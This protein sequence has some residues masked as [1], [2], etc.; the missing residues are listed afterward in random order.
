V[1]KFQ[2]L[3]RV[4][5]SITDVV[6]MTVEAD[7]EEEAMN[8]ARRVLELFPRPH[9]ENGVPYCYIEHRVYNDTE[10]EHLENMQSDDGA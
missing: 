6:T 1:E 3:G 10:V 4:K 9:T 8:K 2:L 5:H 7:S